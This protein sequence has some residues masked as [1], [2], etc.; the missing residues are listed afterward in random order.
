MGKSK[1]KRKYIREPQLTENSIEARKVAKQDVVH[2]MVSTSLESKTR[3]DIYGNV[4]KIIDDAI[5]VSPLMI[6]NSLDC[7][8]RRHKQKISNNQLIDKEE[9]GTDKSEHQP[10]VLGLI[11]TTDVNGGIPKRFTLKNTKNLQ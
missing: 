2:R 4:K 10:S 11:C 5:F 9:S 6:E 8:A 3:S 7:A 1:Q